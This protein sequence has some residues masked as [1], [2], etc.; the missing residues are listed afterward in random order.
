MYKK[1]DEVCLMFFTFKIN[2]P[3]K[4]LLIASLMTFI[5]G[6][7]VSAITM[8]KDH[9]NSEKDSD[10]IHNSIYYTKLMEWIQSSNDKEQTKS[11]SSLKGVKVFLRKENEMFTKNII[12]LY[13]CNE[14]NDDWKEVVT[15]KTV[16]TDT[17]TLD[18]KKKL[19]YLK[20]GDEIEITDMVLK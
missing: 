5:S 3:I 6:F 11:N 1:I 8:K 7:I 16:K 9:N 12:K 4:K 14:V 19:E 17:L 2:N 18:I 10:S 15:E 20:N 13:F